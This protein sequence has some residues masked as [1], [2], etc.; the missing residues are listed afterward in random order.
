[1][2]ERTPHF[3]LRLSAESLGSAKDVGA[4]L[5]PELSGESASNWLTHRLTSTRPE[6]FNLA[7]IVLIFQWAK[8]KGAHA[9][10]ELFAELCGYRVVAIVTEA[11]R[12]ADLARQAEAHAQAATS[13][14]AECLER[15]RHAHLNVDAAA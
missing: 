5:K 4:R 1:M 8:A 14:S 2:F 9:G 7:Q 11:E 3:A 10:F 15:M 12:I 13:L 6:R